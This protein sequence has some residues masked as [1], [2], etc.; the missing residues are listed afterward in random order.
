LIIGCW[1]I[2]WF[3]WSINSLIEYGVMGGSNHQLLYGQII[4]QSK[5]EEISDG[6]RG[7]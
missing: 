1:L 5:L 2:D 3:D 7:K 6:E 4:S